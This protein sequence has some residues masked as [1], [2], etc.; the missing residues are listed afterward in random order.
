MKTVKPTNPQQPIPDHRFPI[1]QPFIQW[2]CCT[3]RLL[4][5]QQ[6]TLGVPTHK[7]AQMFASLP[8]NNW[9]QHVQM[10][11]QHTLT[12]FSIDSIPIEYLH[13]TIAI[14]AVFG[15]YIM[16]GMPVFCMYGIPEDVVHFHNVQYAAALIPQ[17]ILRNFLFTLKITV[18]H[19]II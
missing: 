9:F 16:H 2:L 10:E 19:K 3:H 14:S 15:M 8:L 18:K 1:D 17:C 7:G 6:T 13:T 4:V 5:I 12:V 11:P